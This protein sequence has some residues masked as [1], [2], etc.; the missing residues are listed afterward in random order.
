MKKELNINIKQQV[1]DDFE[2]SY[3]KYIKSGPSY[4]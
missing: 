3:N 2:K 1:D 4:S